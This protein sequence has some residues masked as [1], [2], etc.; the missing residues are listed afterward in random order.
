MASTVASPTLPY[1]TSSPSP[2]PGILL[3]PYVNSAGRSPRYGH[4][5]SLPLPPIS[6]PRSS[7]L[8]AVNSP[9]VRGPS[10]PLPRND[11]GSSTNSAEDDTSIPGTHSRTNSIR[12]IRF[13]PLPIPRALEEAEL[14]QME[15]PFTTMNEDEGLPAGAGSISSAG[16]LGLFGAN[17]DDNNT[18]TASEAGGTIKSI[19]SATKSKSKH[20][21]KR[22]LKP[23]LK[24]EKSGSTSDDALWRSPSRDSVQSNTSN[25]GSPQMRRMNLDGRTRHSS[26][27]SAAGGTPLARVQSANKP[28]RQRMLNGRMYGVKHTGFQ[29]IKDEEPAFVEWGHGGAGSVNNRHGAGSSKYAGVQSGEKVS[30]G[31]VASPTNSV[32]GGDEDDG[33]GMAWLRRRR[34][35]RERERQEQEERERVRW[36]TCHLIIC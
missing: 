7:K 4:N 17:P 8:S 15:S 32:A 34:E 31:A 29:N 1:P 24:S 27:G 26:I 2:G 14:A 12:K 3:N 5:A 9:G 30:I 18:D 36:L 25:E 6:E 13:A 28:R 10:L 20:W 33:S 16:I 23:L 21:S 19:T 35:Q 11:S 22:L